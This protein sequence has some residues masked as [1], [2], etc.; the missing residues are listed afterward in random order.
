MEDTATKFLE[1]CMDHDTENGSL[2]I[3]NKP[4][5]ESTLRRF[6][7]EEA[8]YILT[9]VASVIRVKRNED[10]KPCEGSLFGTTWCTTIFD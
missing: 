1:M 3:F 6:G 2:R 8:K 9:P 5:I 10:E 4:L 7:V